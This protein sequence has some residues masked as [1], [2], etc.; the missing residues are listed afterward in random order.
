MSRIMEDF[1]KEERED[2]TIRLLA[3]LLKSGSM[4]EEN[5]KEL[6]K[7]SKKQM[8]AIKERVTV[9]A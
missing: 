3:I 2:E 9:L 6:F 5:I 1:L 4:S 8:Q 7:L